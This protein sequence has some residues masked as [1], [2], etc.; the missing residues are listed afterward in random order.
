[1]SSQQRRQFPDLTPTAIGS[2]YAGIASGRVLNAKH[3]TATRASQSQQVWNRV[4]LA[5]SAST[6]SAPTPFAQPGPS[7]VPDRFPALGRSSPAPQQQAQQQQQPQKYRGAGQRA[8]PWSASS[9]APPSMRTQASIISS[10]GPA[11]GASAAARSG[12]GTQGPPPKL[13]KA[14]FPDLPAPSNAR[15]K[16]QVRGNV[17]L[18]NILGGGGAPAVAAWGAST[19]STESSSQAADGD[20]EADAAPAPKG[21]KGKGKQKQ[22]LFT[23]GSFPT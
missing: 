12:G 17:S 13:S 16:P 7:R 23:L 4:A 14:L 3:A 2:G 1:M 6:S 9:A 19:G 18:R 15:A 8:T 22:T 20:T 5:A 21:K 11:L 10:T